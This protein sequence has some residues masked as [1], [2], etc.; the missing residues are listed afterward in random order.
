MTAELAPGLVIEWMRESFDVF[1]IEGKLVWRAPPKNH[2]RLLNSEAGSFRPTKYGKEYCHVKMNRRALKRGH[3]IFL[4]VWGRWP[5]PCLDHI[6]GNSRNDCI[7]NLREATIAQ[8]AWNH[9]GRKKKSRLPMGVRKNPSGRYAARIAINKRSL[10]LGTFRTIKE[11]VAVYQK[12][13]KEIFGE[14]A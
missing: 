5:R 12:K 7:D 1:P 14:F 4:W 10:S 11:A 9:K 6:D 3:L 8:N 13:R 2:Q